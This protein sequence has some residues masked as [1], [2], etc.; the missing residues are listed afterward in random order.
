MKY[1]G[2]PNIGLSYLKLYFL[3]MFN[4]D[5]PKFGLSCLQSQYT[6][7]KFLT[8]TKKGLCSNETHMMTRGISPLFV[9]GKIQG[10]IRELLMSL[11]NIYITD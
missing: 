5:N 4:L 7:I 3:S 10:D 1:L 2:N 11:F 9:D 8:N 6:I